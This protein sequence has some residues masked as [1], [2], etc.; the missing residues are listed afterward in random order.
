MAVTGF[1][2]AAAGLLPRLDVSRFTNLAGGRYDLI[3]GATGNG[4]HLRFF[5]RKVL[6]P[7]YESRRIYAGTAMLVLAMLAPLLA[8]RRFAVPYFF[9]FTLT[10]Y[11]LMLRTNVVH[12]LFYLVPRFEE[13]HS[14]SSYRIVGLLLIGPAMLAGATVDR[15][16]RMKMHPA[17][18]LVVIYPPI[19]YYVIREDMAKG[20]RYLPQ[21]VWVALLLTTILVAAMIAIRSIDRWLPASKHGLKRAAS[22]CV[23]VIPFL[24]ILL[25]IYNPLGNDF[26]NRFRNVDAATQFGGNDAINP[27][28]DARYHPLTDCDQSEGAAGFLHGALAGQSPEPLRFFGFDPIELRTAANPDGN[29]YQRYVGVLITP[30]LLVA[31]QASCLGL[32]DVQGYNPM[33]VQRYVDYLKAINGVTLNYHDAVI[34]PTGIS[35]PLI[36]LLNAHYVITPYVIPS[37]RPELLLVQ[38]SMKEVF[39]NGV[40]RVFENPDAFPHAW[41]VHEAQQLPKDQVL[42]ALQ[43]GTIDPRQTVLIEQTPPALGAPNGSPESVTFTSYSPDAMTMRVSTGSDGMLV[44]SEVF[45]PGWNAYV[46]GKKVDIYAAD[47]V[48]RGIHVPA[49]E[50][51]VTMRYELRSLRVG[52]AISVAVA[53]FLLAIAGYLAWSWSSRW[54]ARGFNW[55]RSVK[56]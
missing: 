3:A 17:W 8:R 32:Y 2:L 47:Y 43:S 28:I 46:D 11:A 5:F 23:A 50:H 1:G 45:A 42:T 41:V 18:L 31:N 48:L 52:I 35:S 49:G 39:A 56:P 37:D 21:E 30:E 36:D 26:S 20:R 29:N 13:L 27:Y 53:A 25:L 10:C 12:H 38:S 16:A 54:R 9:V 4:Y 24:L 51:T 55:R 33:Q 14:H 40:I 19:A 34:L 44:V 15:L 22:I 7:T 6:D